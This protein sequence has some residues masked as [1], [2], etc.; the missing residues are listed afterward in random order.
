MGKLDQVTDAK[1]GCTIYSIDYENNLTYIGRVCLEVM[2][3]K[4]IHTSQGATAISAGSA[5]QACS[6][7]WSSMRECMRSW[8]HES[9]DA[10]TFDATA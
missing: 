8:K 1:S 4:G 6:G 5:Q 3:R 10:S 2:V 9:M 7:V